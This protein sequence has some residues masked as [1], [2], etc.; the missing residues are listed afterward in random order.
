MSEGYF[1]VGLLMLASLIVFISL[2]REVKTIEKNE[3][4]IITMLCGN[5]KSY[6]LKNGLTIT[7]TPKGC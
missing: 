3:N 5:Q 7:I 4:R 2:L 6:Q 1:F